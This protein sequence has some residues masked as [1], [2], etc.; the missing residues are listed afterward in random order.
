MDFLNL[1]QRSFETIDDVWLQQLR[2]HGVPGM[3]RVSEIAFAY[4]ARVD[5]R[6]SRV[7]RRIRVCIL[8][9]GAHAVIAFACAWREPA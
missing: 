2:D 1:P 8:R 6:A 7:T 9:M 4:G 5:E 3:V